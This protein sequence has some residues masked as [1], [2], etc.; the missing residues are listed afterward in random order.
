[1]NLEF[2]SHQAIFDQAVKHLFQQRQAALLLR[3][4][5]LLRRLSGRQLHQAATTYRR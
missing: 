2:L 4:P 1:M 3:V 5:W